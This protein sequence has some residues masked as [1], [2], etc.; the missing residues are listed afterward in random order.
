VLR[1]YESRE[2]IL[3]E[4]LTFELSGWVAGDDATPLF[5]VNG[6]VRDVIAATLLRDHFHPGDPPA[7]SHGHGRGVGAGA[8]DTTTRP[9]HGGGRGL[10]L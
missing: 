3:P 4:F 8:S 5:L 10:G 2:A 9:P 6:R 7:S 1:Y